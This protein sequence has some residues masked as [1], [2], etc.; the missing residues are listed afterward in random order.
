MTTLS[1]SIRTPGEH[2]KSSRG[3]GCIPKPTVR[4]QAFLPYHQQ[5]GATDHEGHEKTDGQAR[6][7]LRLTREQLMVLQNVFRDQSNLD[8]VSSYQ[9]FTDHSKA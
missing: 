5:Q 8:L 1:L 7:K 4:L 9:D 2:S 6:K 3:T